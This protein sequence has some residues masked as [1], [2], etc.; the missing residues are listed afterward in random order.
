MPKLGRFDDFP[1]ETGCKSL[2]FRMSAGTE[3]KCAFNNSSH[4]SKKNYFNKK[5][6]LSISTKGISTILTINAPKWRQSAGTWKFLS[7]AKFLST[8]AP[9]D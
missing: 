5:S 9:L 1:K 2:F 8:E 7:N 3:P 4:N 6:K